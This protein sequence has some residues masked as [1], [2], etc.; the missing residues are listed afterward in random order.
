MIFANVSEDDILLREK[1]DEL[2]EEYPEQLR[3]FYVLD[4]PPEWG[5][6]GGRGFISKAMLREFMPEPLLGHLAKVL[7]CGPPGMVKHLAGDLPSKKGQGELG[8]L[9]KEL[10]FDA[11]QVFKF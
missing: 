4:K 5:W 2:Q 8:G 6:K 1:I 3:V 11:S 10:G 9:L 7:V